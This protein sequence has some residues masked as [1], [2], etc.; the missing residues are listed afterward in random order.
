VD[1]HTAL[2][3]AAEQRA[4]RIGAALDERL[5]DEA[6]G[7]YAYYDAR[8]GEPITCD[9]V[10]SYLPLLASIDRARAAR[11]EQ[12][13]RARFSPRYPL[14][15][16][17]PGDPAF[18]ARRYWRGPTW[19][20]INWLLV[21]RLGAELR[22]ATIALVEASGFREYYHP[23]TGEGLGAEQFAWTAALTLDLL[24]RA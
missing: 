1:G 4:A 23:E 6:T 15:S 24:R 2:A 20:N 16:T 9:V 7:R 11:L 17:A 18:D 21:P 13:L 3:R 10:G 22:R 8:A 14:P 12:G 19:I 5:W